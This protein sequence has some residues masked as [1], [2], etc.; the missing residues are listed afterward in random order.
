MQ[1]T[2]ERVTKESK[3][4]VYGAWKDRIYWGVQAGGI[5]YD[6]FQDTKPTPGTVL[7]LQIETSEFKGRTY[8]R[9]EVLL[10]AAGQPTQPSAQPTAQ[11]AA[12]PA[13][14]PPANTQQN[15]PTNGNTNR[16]TPYTHPWAE[17]EA[18]A[19]K[20]HALAWELEA[21]PEHGQPRASIFATIMIGYGDGKI[22][23]SDGWVTG[24]DA[25]WPTGPSMHVETQA[26]LDLENALHESGMS[27]SDMVPRPVSH[28][29]ELSETEAKA[30]IVRINMQVLASK[31]WQIELASGIE[32]YCTDNTL[33]FN[34]E[35]FNV[36]LSVA[37]TRDI[38]NL[39]QSDAHEACKK[40]QT[41]PKL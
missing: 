5:W 10:P 17:Y 41:L 23:D 37:G 11:P 8:R 4:G 29:R 6:V 18:M 13:A 2:V 32:K 20:A 30:G 35:K 15:R 22:N 12:Q 40:L 36:L 3:T 34:K 33:D 38:K 21:A 19:R 24:K 9:C 39:T 14:Q 7:N 26:H 31:N 1:I 16:T 25:G 27:L 28:V